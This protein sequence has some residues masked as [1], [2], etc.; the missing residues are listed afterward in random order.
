MLLSQVVNKLLNQNGLTNASAAE[1]ARLSASN[2]RL[3]KV[4]C[5]DTRLKD[6]CLSSELFEERC[7]V[8]NRI[9]INVLMNL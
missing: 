3:E 5:L 8:V 7:W 1:E 4:D 2:I 9:K 6:L